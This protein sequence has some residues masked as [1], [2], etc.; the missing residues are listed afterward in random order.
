MKKATLLFIILL[1]A[2][3]ATAQIGHGAKKAFTLDDT[4]RG[5]ITPERAWWDLLHYDLNVEVDVAR[6]FFRGS[7]VIRYKALQ[8]HNIMQVDL[9]EPLELTEAYQGDTPLKFTKK[10]ANAWFIQLPSAAGA[11]S[12][13]EITV[14]YEGNPRVARRAPWDGGVSWAKDKLGRAFVATSCQGLGASVWWPCKDHMYDEPDLGM[15]ITITVPDSLM[16]VS[17]GLLASK[18]TYADGKVT[19]VWEVKNPINNYGVNINA[20]HY[21][22]YSEIYPGEKGPLKV[23]YWPLDYNLEVAREHFKDVPRMLQ[24]FEHWFGP[25]PFYEDGFKLVEVPY[26]GMEH[27]SS[28]TYGNQYKKGYLGRDL[29]GTGWGLKWDFIIIHESGHEWFANNITYKDIAD[30]WVHEGFTSYSESLFIDYHYGKQA[31]EDY[32]IGCR[33]SIKNDIPIIGTY[34]VNHEGSGD[35]YSKGANMLHTIRHII[36][37][38]EKF[39]QILRGLNSDFYHKTVTSADVEKYISEKAGRNLAR[40]FD[41]YLR[42]VRI[43]KLAT[44]VKGSKISYRWENVIEGFDMPVKVAIDGKEQ[45]LYPTTTWK[46]VKGKA[47]IANRNFY[48]E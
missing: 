38:D 23:D 35:M 45:L 39:R 48:I 12:E 36:G 5:S 46:S 22:H 6:K 17:N 26:L 13:G 28:V 30:M 27:Q 44:T 1:A 19:T 37:D 24:A 9:Q 32:V 8:S 29:S 2:C 10:G 41:Q 21:A 43:P 33:K 14:H 3:A 25:Y 42:D 11:G 18:C 34:N 15:R 4:L 7:N 31:G 47:L 16:N 20:G 40:V